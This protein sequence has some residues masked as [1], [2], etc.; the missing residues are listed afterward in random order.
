MSHPNCTIEDIVM[1]IPTL[2]FHYV[3][4]NL[5]AEEHQDSEYDEKKKCYI[6]TSCNSSLPNDKRAV[7]MHLQR[8]A[9]E[10]A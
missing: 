7:R 5:D 4:E 2:E 8:A 1:V 6:C 10:P 3:D 9:L